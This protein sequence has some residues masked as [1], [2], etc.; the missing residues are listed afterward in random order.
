MNKEE[1][2]A[3]KK[4]EDQALN[5]VLLW[6]GGAV[7]LEFFL[8]LYHRFGINFDTRVGLAAGLYR[9]LQIAS[10]VCL[11]LTVAAFIWWVLCRK[12]KAKSFA[13]GLLTII[14]ASL[15][16]CTFCVWVWPNTGVQFLYVSVP[17]VA[18]LALIYYLYQ[19]EFFLV[20]LQGGLTLFAMWA[21]RKGFYRS[22]KM[23]YA[24]M[25]GVVVL[26]AAIIVCE[27]LLQRN[28]GRLGKFRILPKKA[29]YLPLYIAGALALISVLLVFILSFVFDRLAPTAAYGCLIGNVAWLFGA[30]VYYTVRLM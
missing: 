8:L 12:K 11:I 6:F 7:I 21:Y 18:V 22:Q 4:K 26:V 27:V 9:F 29:N 24:I 15:F 20:A 25:V 23:V 10:L 17:V 30:A 16:V 13:P 28:K 5:R 1:R 2:L 14:F 3:K 19:R